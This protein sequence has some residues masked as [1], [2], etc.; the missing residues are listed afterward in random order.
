MPLCV[1]KLTNHNNNMDATPN[2]LGTRLVTITIVT[3]PPHHVT[4]IPVTPSSQSMCYT[5]IT[6]E[7]IDVIENPLLY[8]EQPSLVYSRHLA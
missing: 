1:S 7:L 6:T 3:I 4:V 8:I 5:Y 2:R